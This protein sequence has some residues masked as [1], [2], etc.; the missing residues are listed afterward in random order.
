[1]LWYGD[2][3]IFPMT[4]SGPLPSPDMPEDVTKVFDEARQIVNHSPRASAALL[5]LAI[6][7]LC[8]HLGRPGENLSKDI[9]SLVQNGLPVKIQQAL[10]IVRVIGNDAVHPGQIDI[11]DDAQTV[12]EMFNLINLIVDYMITMPKKINEMYDKLP[13]SARQAIAKRDK[14]T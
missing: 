7:L 12:S 11:R 6:Q 8:K 14:S 9:A 1:M 13:E 2:C 5:R 10:D 4:P 3:M